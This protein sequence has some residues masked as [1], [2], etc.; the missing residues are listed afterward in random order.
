MSSGD[1]AQSAVIMDFELALR[2]AKL[3]LGSAQSIDFFGVSTDDP[4]SSSPLASLKPIPEPEKMQPGS[5]ASSSNIG[6]P[7]DEGHVAQPPVQNQRFSKFR[8][9]PVNLDLEPER[10]RVISL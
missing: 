10:C 8:P 1:P 7:T 9:L 2:M 4:L 3:Q 6:N 5:Q